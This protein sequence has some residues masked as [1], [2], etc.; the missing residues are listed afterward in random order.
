MYASSFAN[1]TVSNAETDAELY[2][3]LQ[4]S[5]SPRI[6][7]LTAPLDFSYELNTTYTYTS[8]SLCIEVSMSTS[9]NAC[10]DFLSPNSRRLRENTQTL[11]FCD[12]A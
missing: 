9:C 11:T 2:V 12:R 4:P 8:S 1:A 6:I 10:V 5:T 7:Y 3:A